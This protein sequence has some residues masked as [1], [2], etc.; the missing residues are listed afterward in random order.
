MA[1]TQNLPSNKLCTFITSCLETLWG[2]L[3]SPNSKIE[4][5][6]MMCFCMGEIPKI[7]LSLCWNC[8]QVS[9]A[10]CSW[11]QLEMFSPWA[12]ISQKNGTFFF[13]SVFALVVKD[14]E[15][16]CLQIT[17]QKALFSNQALPS[18][19]IKSVRLRLW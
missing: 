6:S 15:I 14:P 9:C 2:C 3:Y 8:T 7:S 4:R 13:A 10:S 17:L 1:W 5:I 16:V 19:L 12:I 18:Q 11:F